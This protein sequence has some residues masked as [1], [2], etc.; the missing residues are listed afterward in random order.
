MDTTQYTNIIGNQGIINGNNNNFLEVNPLMNQMNTIINPNLIYQMNYQM[1]QMNQM[2]MNINMMNQMNYQM[3]NNQFIN[4]I[5]PMINPMN[6]QMNPIINNNMNL[7]Q[8]N[9]NNYNI[10]NNQN[11]IIINKD[12]KEL[13]DLIIKFYKE[14]GNEFMNYENK[15]QIISLMNQLDPNYSNFVLSEKIYDP[16][17]YIREDKIKIKFIN[18]NYIL[19]N[20]KIPKF[21]TKNELYYISELYKVFDRTN[22]LLIH[23]NKIL[24]KDDS[25]I[26]DISEGDII[27]IIEDRNFADDSYYLFLQEKYA[28]DDKMNIYIKTFD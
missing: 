9:T 10:P 20:V 6:N 3:M 27:I 5:N 2:M 28:N 24:A 12:K 25:S 21:L 15:K 18:S 1:N 7:T 26:N 23:K 11:D 14:N 22:S 4:Q 13:I 16:M 17:P 8:I 19:L